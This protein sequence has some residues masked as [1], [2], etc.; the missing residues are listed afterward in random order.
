MEFSVLALSVCPDQTNIDP[1]TPLFVLA[2]SW[3]KHL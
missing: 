1:Y 3:Y 2:F